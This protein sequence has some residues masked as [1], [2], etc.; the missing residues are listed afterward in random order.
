M[1]HFRVWG[2]VLVVLLAACGEG[3][4]TPFKGDPTAPTFESPGKTANIDAK[5]AAPEGPYCKLN[6]KGEYEGLK[7]SIA[8]QGKLGENFFAEGGGCMERPLREIWGASQNKEIAAWRESDLISF[9]KS[10][11]K[12]VD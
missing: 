12:R 9:T 11:D 5:T 4:P 3:P 8:R 10:D 6:A 7:T 1:W 2:G